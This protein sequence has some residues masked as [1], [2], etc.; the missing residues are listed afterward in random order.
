MLEC[1]VQ[2]LTVSPSSTLLT[3]GGIGLAVGTYFAFM[4]GRHEK[5]EKAAGANDEVG[6][7]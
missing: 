4:T 3:I 5:T 1:I 6:K 7:T 2:L